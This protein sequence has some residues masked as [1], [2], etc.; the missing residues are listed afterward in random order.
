MKPG[1]GL[2]TDKQLLIV[3]VLQ[4]GERTESMC[5]MLKTRGGLC[6]PV[7]PVPSRVGNDYGENTLW[8]L[9]PWGQVAQ[10]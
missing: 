5:G 1:T 8:V 3:P 9:S 4:C 7:A 6:L 10:T 2:A